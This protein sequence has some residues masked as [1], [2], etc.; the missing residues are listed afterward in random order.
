M[1]LKKSE[2][3]A[4]VKLCCRAL[5]EKKV[6]DLRVIDVSEQSSITDFL[7]L[8]TGTSSPHLRA[9]R[10]EVEKVLDAAKA[11]IVGMEIPHDSGW[12]V[13]DAFD[14]MIHLFT[15]D[16]RERYALE[17]LWKDALEISVDKLLSAPKPKKVS[18]PK[19]KAVVK[20]PLKKAAPKG[21]ALRK[22]PSGIE[23]K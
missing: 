3:L 11:Q 13:I 15:A 22:K 12:M 14:V 5:E 8:A 1:K 21:K 2:S 16:Q 9:L 4:L 7:I 6:E 10:I 23:R 18:T 17:N 19:K 20:I